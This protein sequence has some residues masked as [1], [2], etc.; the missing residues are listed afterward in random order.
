MARA[1]M[2]AHG[3]TNQGEFGKAIAFLDELSPDRRSAELAEDPSRAALLIMA[4]A[5]ASVYGAH[6]RARADFI[7]ALAIARTAGD[8]LVLGYV[9]AH[10]GALLLLDGDLG[11]A[12]PLHEEA[13]AIARSIGDESLSGEAHQLLALEDMACCDLRSAAS[14]LTASVR[15]YRSLD[16]F[17][18]LA[19]C[20]TALS[21]LAL[22]RGDAQLTT[23]L[24]G[25]AAAVR[26][27]FGL[28][29]WPWVLEV[30]NHVVEQVTALLAG[31]EY[32][33][34]LAAGRGQTIEDALTDALPILED[35]R[36]RPDRLGALDC[37]SAL[38]A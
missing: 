2:L 9:Q 7:K 18:G 8:P 17:E 22:E 4:R 19:R 27:Q 12:R 10:Y 23:R 34:Q 37:C 30:E 38:V 32:A 36:E 20:L 6:D 28:K 5:I 21:V 25:A 26:D 31:D 15:H 1:W 16:H 33:G 3:W 14:H 11:Q 35:G 13:L 29:R 24:I